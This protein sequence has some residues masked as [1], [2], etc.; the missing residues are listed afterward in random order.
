MY[1]GSGERVLAIQSPAPSVPGSDM[2]PVIVSI[3][4]Y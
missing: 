3:V 2:D 4:R 1:H